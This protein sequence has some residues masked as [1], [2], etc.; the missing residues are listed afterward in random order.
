[1]T[2][3]LPPLPYA[4]DALAPHISANTF[5]FHH[6]KHHNAYVT[7]LNELVAG[8]EFEKAS[9]E[10]IIMASAKDASKAGLFN[11]AAQH[12]N[13]SFFWHCLTPNGGGKPSGE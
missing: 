3:T 13:H 8:T 6:G 4:K 10:D 11:N 2:F 9:L 12:W 7:K 1:M 5:D